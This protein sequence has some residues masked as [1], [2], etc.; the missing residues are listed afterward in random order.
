MEITSL[1]SW[2]FIYLKDLLI[3]VR[4]LTRNRIHY[5]V[6]RVRIAFISIKWRTV[7]F[8][9]TID[10][11]VTDRRHWLAVVAN[12][13]SKPNNQTIVYEIV[14]PSVSQQEIVFFYVPV[15]SNLLCGVTS[16]SHE[17][18]PHPDPARYL[19][20]L[21]KRVADGS[22]RNCRRAV[23]QTTTHTVI[24]EEKQKEESDSVTY[25]FFI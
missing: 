10:M 11:C 21:C 6:L 17:T 19:G 3:K 4:K 25:F 2:L 14:N 13:G 9:V 20:A 5:I 23:K 16:R 1:S 8:K 24:T 7:N 12:F 18:H 22:H 15:A